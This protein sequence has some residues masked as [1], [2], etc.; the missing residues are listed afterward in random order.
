VDI[1][2]LPPAHRLARLVL[3]VTLLAT[4]GAGATAAI[5]T[6]WAARV[7]ADGQDIAERARAIW[8]GP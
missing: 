4:L 6:G 5:V 3:A 7:V 2:L 1:R 8:S